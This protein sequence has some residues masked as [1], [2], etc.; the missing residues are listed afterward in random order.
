MAGVMYLGNQM[1]SP[2][3]IQ[4]GGEPEPFPVRGVATELDENGYMED[5][6]EVS[7]NS[8]YKDYQEL[9]FYF[10]GSNIIAMEYSYNYNVERIGSVFPVFNGAFQNSS[11]RYV[12]F[13]NLSHLPDKANTVGSNRFHFLRNMIAGTNGVN[14]YFRALTTQTTYRTNVFAFMCEGATD[15]VIHFPSNLENIISGLYNYPLF[16]G[17][18]TTVAFD[19]PA[20]S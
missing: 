7:Y 12:D 18:N 17:T 8:L 10:D 9:P 16:R 2:V 4:G 1:V 13:P 3:I 5:Y 6:S 19:L 15:A 20:T 11:I 14:I